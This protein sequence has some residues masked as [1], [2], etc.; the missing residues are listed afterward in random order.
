VATMV[1]ILVVVEDVLLVDFLV[2]VGHERVKL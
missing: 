2:V 1:R